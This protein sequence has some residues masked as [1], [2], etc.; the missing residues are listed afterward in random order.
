MNLLSFDYDRSVPL[1]FKSQNWY[2]NAYFEGPIELE[3]YNRNF[4]QFSI[5]VVLTDP[6]KYAVEGTKTQLFLTRY[7][8]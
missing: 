7:Q 1:Q 6:Y 8:W 3:K 2:W 5:N 4:W